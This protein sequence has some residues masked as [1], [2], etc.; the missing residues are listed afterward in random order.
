MGE[1][2]KK[3][4]SEVVSL[5]FRLTI[6]VLDGRLGLYGE[7]CCGDV[8]GRW[9]VKDGNDMS[10][11]DQGLWF[12]LIISRLGAE[13]CARRVELEVKLNA[14]CGRNAKR[15]R[16]ILYRHGDCFFVVLTGTQT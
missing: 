14:E 13:V 16:E 7:G 9:T 6:V 15:R 4:L 8:L 11:V 3:L 1:S 2:L 12:L 10:F 5:R